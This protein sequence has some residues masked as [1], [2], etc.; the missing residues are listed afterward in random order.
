MVSLIYYLLA[1]VFG[2]GQSAA[3][4]GYHRLGGNATAF[5]ALKTGAALLLFSFFLFSPDFSFSVNGIW[6]GVA[7]GLSLSVSMYSG[8]LALCLGP[9]ALSGL[10]VS[11]SVLM[12]IGYAAFF[13]GEVLRPLQIPGLC[14][15]A[16]AMFFASG[17]GT[18]AKKRR[19]AQE[20]DSAEDPVKEVC[21]TK[22][23]RGAWLLAVS[24][25]FLANGTGA[26]L[27]KEYGLRGSA[28]PGEFMFFAMLVAFSLFFLVALFKRIFKKSRQKPSPFGAALAC[29]AGL[30]NACANYATTALAGGESAA[31]LFPAVSVGTVFLSL[32]AGRLLFSEKI[33][34]VIC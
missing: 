23:K 10:L 6:F 9:M 11:F 22:K 20:N 1:V 26:I 13:C 28:R 18:G 32:L 27:Q 25:T 14:C 19:T 16:V 5:N 12:P 15:F 30:S 3:A 17:V 7:Y 31:F 34:P 4:K 24:V 2:V 21:E 8:Y 33:S 29:I